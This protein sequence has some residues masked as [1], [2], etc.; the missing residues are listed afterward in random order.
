MKTTIKGTTITVNIHNDREKRMIRIIE[1]CIDSAI[2]SPKSECSQREMQAA[3]EYASAL[4]VLEI[5]DKNIGFLWAGGKCMYY[6]NAQ[7][8]EVEKV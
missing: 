7:W 8:Y 2:N 1:T 5:T 3:N 4:S 6:Y